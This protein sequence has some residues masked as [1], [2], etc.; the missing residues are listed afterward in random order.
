[1][2]IP[3]WVC[4]YFPFA[5]WINKPENWNYGLMIFIIMIIGIILTFIGGFIQAIK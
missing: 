3:I 5:Q 1:M 4:S 2:W